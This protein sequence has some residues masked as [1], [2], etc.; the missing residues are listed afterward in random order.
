MFRRTSRSGS[1]FDRT[2]NCRSLRDRERFIDSLLEFG[3]SYEWKDKPDR[4]VGQWFALIRCVL[5]L[6]RLYRFTLR[7]GGDLVDSCGR[8][9]LQ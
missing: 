5:V 8:L 1:A 7:Q 4:Q 9:Q 2:Q 6:P 3:K